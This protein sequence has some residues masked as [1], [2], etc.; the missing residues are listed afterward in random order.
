MATLR[1]QFRRRERTVHDAQSSHE[2][3]RLCS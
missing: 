2:L 3:S 1:V